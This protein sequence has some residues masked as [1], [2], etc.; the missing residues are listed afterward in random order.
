[1]MTKLKME[2]KC[3]CQDCKE[4]RKELLD[5]IIDFYKCQNY[6]MAGKGAIINDLEQFYEKSKLNNL[7]KK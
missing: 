5:R 3:N 2:Y 6:I 7:Q 1:M 4:A